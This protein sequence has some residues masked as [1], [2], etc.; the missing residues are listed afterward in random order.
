MTGRGTILFVDDE[1]P[2]RASAAEWLTLSGFAVAT[3][4]GADAAEAQLPGRPFDAVVTDL[5]MPGRDGMALLDAVG[6]ADPELPVVMLTG[7]GDVAAAVDA[8]RRGAHDFLEK[9]YDADHLVAVLDRAVRQRR[10]SAELARL[11]DAAGD[12]RG[13]ADRLIGVSP[14]IRA[15]RER[16]LK[17]AA[18]DVDVLIVGETGT[19]KEI[20]ARALHDL[21][22]R[23]AGNFVAINC[24][25]VPESVFE[26][27]IFGH[28]RGAFTGASA[29]R[30]GKFAFAAGGTVFLDEIESMPP[31][32]Q[33]K[34]LR[35]IQERVVEPLGGNRQV[36]L[37]V[38]FVAA[39]KVNLRTA[40]GTG[41]FRA[42]LYYRL[43]TVEIAVPPLR[44]R[45]EDIPLLYRTF[46]AEAARRFGLPEPA[47]GAAELAGLAARPWP[48]NVRE[49]KAHAD[50][51]ALALDRAPPPVPGA[52]HTLP[53]QVARFETERIRAALEASEWRTGEAADRLGI[54]RRTLNEKI[55]R[56]SI[57]RAG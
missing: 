16:V 13:I 34:V 38:R 57:R 55:A 52:G 43:G 8:M 54:P 49:L 50:R 19:G 25:A 42:D 23:A 45:A 37:D 10:L 28:V 4:D 26:S 39:S 51:A 21:G 44:D 46:L 6:R 48:G 15:L 41:G 20:A 32:L 7:H 9:P 47:V 56:Y 2:V 40:S 53:E 18:V 22:P 30:V 33:V 5:R 1:A 17:L 29:D 14:V 12:R 27:E 11:R 36:P 31:A 3:A 35:A 24:A